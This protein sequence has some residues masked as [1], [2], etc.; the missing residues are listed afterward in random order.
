MKLIKMEIV[1]L[2]PTHIKTK[3][4][5][6]SLLLISYRLLCYSLEKD[7]VNDYQLIGSKLFTSEMHQR[8]RFFSFEERQLAS[9]TWEGS[10]GSLLPP[11]VT[12]MFTI[13][14]MYLIARVVP[15]TDFEAGSGLWKIWLTKKPNP[16]IR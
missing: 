12:T 14:I 3:N 5:L 11:H 4:K 1:F 13:W 6:K 8:T 16:D 7:S 15:E 2:L 9:P 10:G